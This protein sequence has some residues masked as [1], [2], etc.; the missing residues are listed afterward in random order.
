[1]NW[2][3]K[4]QSAISDLEVESRETKGH[5]WHIRYPEAGG[6]PESGIVVATTRPETML[7]DTAVAVHPEDARYQALVGKRLALPLSGRE[8]PVV[9]DAAV[10]AAFGTGAVKVT[11]AHDPN[12]FEIGSRHKLEA[13]KVIGPDGKMTAEALAYAGFSREAARDKVV[14]DLEAGGFLVKTE[15]HRHA[16][17]I[18]YRCSTTIEPLL[19]E[20]WFVRMEGLAKPAIEAAEKG[21][22]KIFP[23]NWEKPYLEWL[24]NLK[25]WCVSR[26]IW[27]GHRIPVWY[28]RACF[29]ARGGKRR[30]D[31]KPQVGLAAPGRCLVCGGKDFFQDPDVLDTWFSSALWPFSV[32]GWPEETA[33]LKALYPTD[34][35]VTGYEILY[36]WVARMQMM[37]LRFRKAVPFRRA[38]IHGIVRDKKGRK[39]SK[40]LG[41]VV[42]PLD[43]IPKYGADALRFSLLSQAHPGRDI[44]FAEDS[45]I[46]P[47]NFA[48]KIWNAT[49]FALSNLPENLPGKRYELRESLETADKWI[50]DEFYGMKREIADKLGAF[51]IAAA[52]DAIYSFLWDKFCD[53]YLELSKIRL[54]GDDEGSKEIARGV[55]VCVLAETLRLLSPFMPFITE[56][57][58]EALAPYAGRLPEQRRGAN[59]RTRLEM[60]YVIGVTSALRSLRANLNVPPGRPIHVKAVGDGGAAESLKAHA[61]YLRALARIERLDFAASD[62]KPPHSATALACGLKFYVPLEG[63]IDLAKERARLE[64]ELS[65]VEAELQKIALKTENPDFLA[66]APEPEKALARAAHEAA[67]GKKEGLLRTL[68]ELN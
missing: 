67:K 1:M 32:F 61:A 9:A 66:R 64:K 50:L 18:C 25:D 65:K 19:S 23:A 45:L 52:A 7:G 17:G 29:D 31:A 4:F 14:A 54:Q 68:S 5:L 21:E 40:S 15:E 44:P 59:P 26:Q 36:L 62:A 60:S 8:I 2:D 10:E 34:V 33:D 24:R 35:L 28:C 47:R 38:L 55:L 58:L 56:E 63:L 53:W 22:F 48:N 30:P 46:G 37:G 6:G 11:P 39:M 20:Q 43:M 27:W 3:P 13:I 49:R 16:V 51:E 41:N 57:L 12:D 42:D